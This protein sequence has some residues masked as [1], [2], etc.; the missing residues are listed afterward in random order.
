MGGG[1]GSSSAKLKP[2]PLENVQADILRQVES[3][4]G[5]PFRQAITPG[6]LRTIGGPGVFQTDLPAVDRDVIESQFQQARSGLLSNIPARGGQLQQQLVNLEA[7]RAGDV[8]GAINQ[9]GQR[10][11]ERALSLTPTFLPGAQQLGSAVQGEQARRL[12]QFQA[13]QQASA[14][15]GGGLGQLIGGGLGALG[16]V[17][18]RG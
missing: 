11:I 4:L 1:K 3:S 6:V 7:A 15:K 18:A 17:F 9:A 5:Q 10:G 2:G 14:S 13:Q 16:G 12:A 8:S